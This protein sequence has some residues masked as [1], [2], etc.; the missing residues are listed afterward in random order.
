M[1]AS[2]ASLDGVVAILPCGSLETIFL[3]LLAICTV[4]LRSSVGRERKEMKSKGAALEG[5]SLA[6]VSVLS[7]T[8]MLCNVIRDLPGPGFFFPKLVS[9]SKASTR[10]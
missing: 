10:R 4:V 3:A 8:R 6:D 9:T 5:P 2:S 7:L 1:Y